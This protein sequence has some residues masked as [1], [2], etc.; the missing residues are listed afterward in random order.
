VLAVS[1]DDRIDE[2]DARTAALRTQV[3]AAGDDALPQLAA[4][5]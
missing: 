4:A 3:A 5:R 1:K 2:F